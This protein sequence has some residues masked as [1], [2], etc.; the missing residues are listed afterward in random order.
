MARLAT[1]VLLAL[2]PALE[3]GAPA[4][5]AVAAPRPTAADCRVGIGPLTPPTGRPH[6]SLT[7]R[8]GAGLRAVAGKLTV[9]FAPDL[10]TDRLVFRLWPNAA[11]YAKWGAR[12]RV[13]HVVSGHE[14]LAISRPNATTLVVARPLGAGERIT[15]S[16]DW[17]LAPPRS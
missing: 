14:T 11:P 16:M 15:V 1:V 8:V 10:A 12:L 5:A 4:P 9:G 17:S 2:L 13:G 6:Y 7:V 3:V